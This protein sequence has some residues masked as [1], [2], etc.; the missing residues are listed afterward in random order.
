[1]D[2]LTELQRTP[3]SVPGVVA[4]GYLIERPL[5]RNMLRCMYSGCE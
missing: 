4:C 3:A 1:M 5:L 2:V